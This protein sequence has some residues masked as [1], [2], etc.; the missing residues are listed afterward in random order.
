[1]DGDVCVCRLSQSSGRYVVD[2]LAGQGTQCVIPIRGADHY[3][4]HLKVCGDVG[5]VCEG[6]CVCVCVC[7]CMCGIRAVIACP[8]VD[9]QGWNALVCLLGTARRLRSP[10]RGSIFAMKSRSL[11]RSRARTSSLT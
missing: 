11:G 2:R 4:R 3:V 1:M 10:L 5:Q 6:E 9:V 8:G 7:V